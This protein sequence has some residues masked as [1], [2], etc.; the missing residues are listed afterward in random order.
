MKKRYFSPGRFLSLEKNM[1]A[2]FGANFEKKNV[3]KNCPKIG[4]PAFKY[5]KK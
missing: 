4:H 2:I 1:G 3:S 5:F